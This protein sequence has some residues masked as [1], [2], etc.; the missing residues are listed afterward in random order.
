MRNLVRRPALLVA[1]FVALS[2]RGLSSGTEVRVVGPRVVVQANGVPLT[3]VLSRF[4]QATG[5]KIVYDAAKPRQLVTVEIDAGSQAEALSQLLEGQGLSYALRLDA[6]GVGVDMLFLMAKGQA[7]A[8]AAP[9]APVA[10]M[11]RREVYDAIEDPPAEAEPTFGEA[12]EPIV[13]GEP[14]ADPLLD[15]A[16]AALAPGAN[17][18]A[19]AP[20]A[21]APGTVTPFTAPWQPAAPS[22]P[23]AASYPSWR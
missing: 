15:P 8:S 21:Q 4:S 10:H 18:P 1:L 22:F 12:Q 19:P 6:S 13:Q 5:T 3:D 14:V 2:G 23:Q 7:A 9:A 11:D 20:G 16:A 17:I